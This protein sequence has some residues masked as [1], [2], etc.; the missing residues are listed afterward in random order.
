MAVL[1]Y[2]PGEKPK[3]VI[4]T[5]VVTNKGTRGTERISFDD[6]RRMQLLWMNMEQF[7]VQYAPDVMGVETY[8]VY[9]PTQ[10]GHAGK[11]TGWKAGFGYALACGVGFAHDIEVIPFLPAD[12]KRRVAGHKSADKLDV[13]QA[14]YGRVTG[15]EDA[16]EGIP[17]RFHEHAADA[18]GHGLLALA[19]IQK[20][21]EADD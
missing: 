9:K 20:E 11:G 6:V 8:T 10:G 7:A 5:V 4:A 18:V 16:L 14:L 13:E 19:H 15:L 3:V 2:T 21:A 17:P 1:D 12:L